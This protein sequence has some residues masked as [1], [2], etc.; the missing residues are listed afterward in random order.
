M[1]DNPEFNPTRNHKL[2]YLK[3][4]R[5]NLTFGRCA[6]KVTELTKLHQNRLV[7]EDV[8]GRCLWLLYENCR[9]IQEAN[10]YEAHMNKPIVPEIGG[11]LRKIV[12]FLDD[13]VLEP[14]RYAVV[15]DIETESYHEDEDGNIID[16]AIT[17]KERRD[18]AEWYS[19]KREPFFENV[20]IGTLEKIQQA[21]NIFTTCNSSNCS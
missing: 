14:Y 20:D 21:E 2:E 6:G 9:I 3:E 4:L 5:A 15:F 10:F 17:E 1:S 19:Q 13:G 7:S 16:P 8:R 12:K 11:I 18:F